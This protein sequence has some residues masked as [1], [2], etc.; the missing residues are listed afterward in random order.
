VARRWETTPNADFSAPRRLCGNRS[1]F[2][3]HWADK[4]VC[5]PVGRGDARS[6]FRF[7]LSSYWSLVLGPWAFPRFGQT[8][9]SALQ[10]DIGGPTPLSALA[11]VIGAWALVIPA[12]RVLP[13]ALLLTRSPLPSLAAC[14]AR[15]GG[16]PIRLA[17]T[18]CV[19][20]KIA[21]TPTRAGRVAVRAEARHPKGLFHANHTSQPRK[22]RPQVVGNGQLWK[23]GL[24][25]S[26]NFATLENE[27][28][29]E[30]LAAT[31]MT[32]TATTPTTSALSKLT[33]GIQA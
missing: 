9:M 23:T 6:A 16:W 33:F 21:L 30:Q 11:W 28:F 26:N 7:P 22:P 13:S 2:T 25:L 19:S 5:P 20:A 10:F 1:E 14:N 32:T 15:G 29:V 12:Q 8:R 24:L 27:T 31:T 4:N 18:F 17:K 3:P